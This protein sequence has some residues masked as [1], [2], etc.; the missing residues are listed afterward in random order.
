MRYA[1]QLRHLSSKIQSGYVTRK[2]RI[3][4]VVFFKP[5][6]KRSNAKNT[7]A[8]RNLQLAL[9]LYIFIGLSHVNVHHKYEVNGYIQHITCVSLRQ[10]PRLS[11]I[12][13]Y[14]TVFVSLL[15]F[16]PTP[17]SLTFYTMFWI[18][19]FL[20]LQK[21]DDYKCV[22][23]FE[24]GTKFLNLNKSTFCRRKCRTNLFCFTFK[25]LRHWD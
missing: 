21:V 1:L 25:Q 14:T 16:T 4:I 7:N 6:Q 3:K 20:C 24:H 12:T 22:T 18:H 17:I 5:E 11:V 8:L 23:W 15:Y 13:P 10:C 2:S 19:V 9:G